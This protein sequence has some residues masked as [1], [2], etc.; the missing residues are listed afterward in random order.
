VI[1]SGGLTQYIET[2]NMPVASAG[3]S[4]GTH[5]LFIDTGKLTPGYNNE[6]HQ[7]AYV[8]NA[9]TGKVNC[10]SC[11]PTHMV[12]EAGGKE[13]LG[14]EA[15]GQVQLIHLINEKEGQFESPS[16]PL[17]SEDGSRAVFETTEALVPQDANGT[18]DVYEWEREGSEGCTAESLHV[19]SLT[20]SAAYSPVDEGCLY[21]LS[22]GLGKEIPNTE[23][24]TAGSHLIGASENL[25]D[26]Y[27]QTDDS[28]VPGVDGSAGKLYD[29]RI[30]GGFPYTA[31]THGCETT[32]CEI[33]TSKSTVLGRPATESFE[34]PGNAKST[35]VGHDNRVTSARKR[36]LDRALK[37]CRR[38]DRGRK[39]AA[40]ERMARR[41]YGA[42]TRRNVTRDGKGRG[43]K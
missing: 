40:C 4:N 16:P 43:S 42:R 7:E 13:H 3:K 11:N 23:H 21:L 36:R 15:T 20:E 37:V 38:H 34:G 5:F 28:L 22:T 8:Y 41:A 33:A 25:K 19:K 12:E 6:E 31:S 35:S 26:V 30:D 27:I 39:R 10:I 14:P 17:I 2:A 1:S 9:E 29:V 18:D 32:E 24:V